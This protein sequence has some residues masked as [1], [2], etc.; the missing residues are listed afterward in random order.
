MDVK[1]ASRISKCICWLAIL[2]AIIWAG[3]P[4]PGSTLTLTQQLVGFFASV[5]VAVIAAGAAEILSANAYRAPHKPRRYRGRRC[6]RD[7]A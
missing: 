5:I 1:T 3:E 7:I 6:R 2:S 4:S